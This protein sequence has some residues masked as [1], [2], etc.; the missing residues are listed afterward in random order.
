VEGPKATQNKKV[1]NEY[2][3]KK[4]QNKNRWTNKCTKVKNLKKEKE[5]MEE[6]L[7]VQRKEK[8]LKKDDSKRRKK[9]GPKVQRLSCYFSNV[10][11]VKFG[12]FLPSFLL[13]QAH[14]RSTFAPRLLLLLLQLIT[15]LIPLLFL[16]LVG[17]IFGKEH[18]KNAFRISSKLL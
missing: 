15:D 6:K 11:I 13:L 18:I 2:K 16:S 17:G 10:I 5:K 12:P 14:S 9:M 1:K 4:K 8:N 3:M 7:A